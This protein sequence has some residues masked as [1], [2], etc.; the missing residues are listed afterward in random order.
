MMCN[1]YVWLFSATLLH[2]FLINKCCYMECRMWA[3]FNPH[4]HP[5]EDGQNCI[6]CGCSHPGQTCGLKYAHILHSMEQ[7]LLIRQP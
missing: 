1:F 5:T 3:Y 6:G 2:G 7:Q 4:Y